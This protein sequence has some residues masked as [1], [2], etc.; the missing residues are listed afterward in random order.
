MKQ[1]EQLKTIQKQD[2]T[3]TKCD[4]EM[5]EVINSEF[6]KVFTKM[7]CWQKRWKICCK[8]SQCSDDV[9]MSIS[10][11]EIIVAIRSMEDGNVL[12]LDEVVKLWTGNV[13]SVIDHIQ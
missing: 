9:K 7:D 13:D 11:D 10:S 6:Q 8:I 3:L 5:A 4:Q 12:G 1:R 2:G